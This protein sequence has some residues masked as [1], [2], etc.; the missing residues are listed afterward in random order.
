MLNSE[1][2]VIKCFPCW[3][4]LSIKFALQ[5]KF[6]LLTFAIFFLLNIAEHVTFFAN[7]S[8]NANYCSTVVGIFLFIS[9]DS[10]MLS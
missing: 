7:E 3:P 10:F 9:R 5:I 8:E 4:M 2:E 6:K 1:P